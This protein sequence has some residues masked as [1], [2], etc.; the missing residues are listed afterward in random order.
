MRISRKLALAFFAII[1]TIVAM[2]GSAL[3]SLAAI[4]RAERAA[5]ESKKAA[6]TALLARMALARVE[7]SYRGWLLSSDP[8]YTGRIDKHEGK[9]KTE[10][11]NLRS[12]EQGRDE[13][14]ALV[15]TAEKAFAKYHDEVI[16]AGQKLAA[17]PATRDAAIKM[18]GPDGSADALITPIEDSLDAIIERETA[19]NAESSVELQL[20]VDH[21]GTALYA[22][23]GAAL[24]IAVGLW[25]LLTRG[26]AAPI[27][28]LTAAM[29]RLAAGDND[30]EVPAAGRRDEIGRM[31]AT[32]QVFRDAQIAK[33]RLEA[34]TVEIRSQT[35]A[36]RQRSEA[37]K[38]RQA[39]EDRV[40]VTALGTG[41]AKLAEGDLSYR[42][43]EAFA[44][45]TQ[46][47]KTDFN[48]AIA[49][50]E[51]TM[52]TIV[53]AIGAINSGTSEISNA[54][55]DLARRTEQQAASLEETS[56]AL[57]EVTGTVKKTANGARQAARVTSEARGDA[58]KS[59]EV[60]REAI[61]AMAG[62]EK[63]SEQISQII[64]VIDEIAFQTNLLALNAGV[65]AARAGET[66]RG[67]AVVASEVRALAQ[68]SADAAKAIKGL[69]STST[70]QVERG[71]GLVGQTGTV[72]EQIARH[73]TEMSAL[74]GDIA[75]S[76]EGQSAA[77]GEV[78]VAV[79]QMDQVTQQ[80]A[81][82]VEE[83]TAASHSLSSEADQ[84]ARL[85]TKFRLGGETSRA[86]P[87]RTV[88]RQQ[89]QRSAARPVAAL[90]TISTGHGS[91][92]VAKQAEPD[93]W[94][95]F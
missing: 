34:E 68:R 21:A 26:I 89:P 91:A 54:A 9:L 7:N 32:V 51:A 28:T 61:A 30:T 14:V 45:K 12:I 40:A 56:A 46:Q 50:L 86:A 36:E 41:L 72:L 80:N 57:A 11:G 58:E 27:R 73:V 29:D 95:E 52:K 47:L 4:E 2:S 37:D 78:N 43:S 22:G 70:Q 55:D 23:L 20:K 84:L 10:L 62:I 59:G 79:N 53:G 44:P 49:E 76:A 82:M 83:S 3:W 94:D 31:A 13:I 5:E 16:V 88:H 65:E 87:P 38:A 90:K 81:A 63:S 33:V 85:V 39:A 77:L 67:F 15:D 69:I 25:L 93:G 42:I 92:A 74:V 75:A 8:Y 64:G 17:D 18:V 1:A 48:T 24:V 35:E 6:D 60:M 19:G 66:G 71:V